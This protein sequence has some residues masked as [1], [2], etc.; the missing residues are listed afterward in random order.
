MSA[1]QAD[2]SSLEQR[3]NT[4]RILR[5]QRLA[6]G[7]LQETPT[8]PL[9]LILNSGYASASAY[10]LAIVAGTYTIGPVT[11]AASASNVQYANLN[12]ALSGATARFNYTDDGGAI[13]LYTYLKFSAG[14][15]YT[16]G[17]GI[18]VASGDTIGNQHYHEVMAMADYLLS[19]RTDVYLGAGWQG[20][21]DVVDRQTGGRRLWQP[22]RFF[23]QQ[24]GGRAYG[25]AASI[26]K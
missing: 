22:W 17:K 5:L 1:L 21:G 4:S 20:V 24:T 11:F 9:N 8:E 16:I 25:A 6:L 13:F 18:T 14:Y 2:R 26:L 10:Q 12:P 23:K 15:N 19:K 7:S 3:S